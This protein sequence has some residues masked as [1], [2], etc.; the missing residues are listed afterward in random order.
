MLAIVLSELDPRAGLV[1][2][3]YTA[4]LGLALVYLGEH[5]VFDVLAGAGLAAGVRLAEPMARLPAR[6]VAALFDAV[7]ELASE[8]G[9]P[10]LRR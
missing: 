8:R 6:R 10:L 5:Y 1:G 3:T 9:R 7:S 2:W 4:A